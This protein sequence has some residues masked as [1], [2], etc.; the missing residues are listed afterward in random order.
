M[1]RSS[2]ALLTG[3]VVATPLFVVLWAVQAFNRDG[4]RPTYHPI[5]LLSLG[6]GGWAQIVNFVLVGLLISGGGIG[7]SRT[8]GSGRLAR[9]ISILV[10]LMGIGLVIA[11][12]FVTDAG[13][14]FPAGAPEGAPVM[15]WH[16]AVHEVGFI[17]TQLAFLA[18]G[19]TLAVLFARNRRRGWA[20]AC[21]AAV[22]AAMLVP[23]LGDLET[24]AIRLFISSVIEM[25]LISAVAL[26]TLLGRVS[27]P[28][29]DSMPAVTYAEPHG[30]TSRSR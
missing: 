13:G 25:G 24:L 29:Q 18:A 11:G 15:S 21:I 17:L 10:I 6:D 27:G 8:L 20:A 9:W 23:A 28:T 22:V 19:I 14:G 2:R 5:S 7:L 16:G 4:F 26:G 12:L 1:S 3:A 30:S